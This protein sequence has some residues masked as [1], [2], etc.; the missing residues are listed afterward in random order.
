MEIVHLRDHPFEKRDKRG[1]AECG[2][3][4]GNLVHVGTP[5]SHNLHGSA[6]NIWS[7]QGIKRAWEE[8]L[9]ELLLATGLPKG[10][11][12]VFV[13]G[14]MIFPD[15]RKRDQGNYRYMIEKALGDTFVQGGWLEDDDWVRY[16]FGRL[17]YAYLKGVSGTVLTV[18]PS[19]RSTAEDPQRELEI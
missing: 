12:S 14:Q 8:K 3:G 5:P 10:L 4:K 15:R 13:E 1:C 18:H 16:E 2:R 6:S 19:W 17:R 11:G 9:T 7:Y